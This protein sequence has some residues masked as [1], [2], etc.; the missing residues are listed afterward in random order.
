MQ[1]FT[2]SNAHRWVTHFTLKGT[3]GNIP[4]IE[5][6]LD[7]VS[8]FNFWSKR[9]LEDTFSKLFPAGIHLETIWICDDNLQPA[10]TS[11]AA[12]DCK[13]CE[14]VNGRAIEPSSGCLAKLWEGS[15]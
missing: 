8:A 6:S 15:W 1:A 7:F 12:V 10:L 9:Q 4:P 14:L 3:I 2:T 11:T 13:L 5:K